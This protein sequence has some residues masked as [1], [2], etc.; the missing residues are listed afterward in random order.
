MLLSNIDKNGD[1][2]FKDQRDER[3]V[4]AHP[5]TNILLNIAANENKVSREELINLVSEKIKNKVLQNI[6]EVGK[7]DVDYAVIPVG[8]LYIEYKGTKNPFYYNS[9]TSRGHVYYIPVT[10]NKASTLMLTK[11]S[12]PQEW[13]AEHA[14][15]K[16]VERNIPI[17]WIKM[18]P[19]QKSE[20]IIN[21]KKTIEELKNKKTQGEKTKKY[22]EEFKEPVAFKKEDLPY[23]LNGDYRP[24]KD[25]QQTYFKLKIFD[26]NKFPIM[27]TSGS[28]FVKDVKV[29]ADNSNAAAIYA[30]KLSGK[31]NGLKP[32]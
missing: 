22:K 29:K 19:F 12:I 18:I 13:R 17:S 10:E 3:L 23:E 32:W 30:S 8:E 25:G 28:V 16:G 27:S 26:K 31:K 2:H 24:K 5:E 21:L 9:K 20:I 15:R 6:E 7:I 4:R 14:G 1:D 11:S